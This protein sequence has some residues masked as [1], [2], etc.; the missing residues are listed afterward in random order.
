[1]HRVAQTASLITDHTSYYRNGASVLPV[2]GAAIHLAAFGTDTDEGRYLRA[3]A[4]ESGEV[5]HAG[6][7][8]ALRL[9]RI[10]VAALVGLTVATLA[11]GRGPAPVLLFTF[12]AIAG[13][14]ASLFTSR[15]LGLLDRSRMINSNLFHYLSTLAKQ[16]RNRRSYLRAA[17][18]AGLSIPL[19]GGATIRS[20]DLVVQ[21]KNLN[22]LSGFAAAAAATM[23]VASLGYLLGAVQSSGSAVIGLVVAAAT[24]YAQGTLAG[25]VWAATLMLITILYAMDILGSRPS[26]ASDPPVLPTVDRANENLRGAEKSKRGVSFPNRGPNWRL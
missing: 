2:L 6:I 8:A 11:A 7:L 17:L 16:R 13:L 4:E 21:S 18:L 26:K 23:L 25:R 1:V 10:G 9:L 15:A 22:N 20:T 14:T 3:V 5:E 12:V 24:W 19:L